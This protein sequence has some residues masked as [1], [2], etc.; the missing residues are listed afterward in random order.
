MF[1]FLHAKNFQYNAQAHPARQLQSGTSPAPTGVHEA[2]A[3][4][5]DKECGQ[6]GQRLS[7]PTRWR[8]L[9]E[10]TVSP[11]T[12]SP[13]WTRFARLL[14]RPSLQQVRLG[15]TDIFRRT[16]NWPGSG[17]RPLSTRWV[18]NA[19]KSTAVLL[20]KTSRF[21]VQVRR[22]QARYCSDWW[23]IHAFALSSPLSC[24]CLEMQG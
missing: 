17:L 8:S 7:A 18:T 9:V 13:L 23:R 10:S 5:S 6:P 22:L 4:G 19:S 20:D 12:S 24:L 14:Q 15:I 16:Q 3:G 11:A 1:F 2:L 21:Y